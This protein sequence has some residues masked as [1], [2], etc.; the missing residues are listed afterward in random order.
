MYCRWIAGIGLPM[1]TD[2]LCGRRDPLSEL[3]AGDGVEAGQQGVHRA[4]RR[5]IADHLAAALPQRG[6]VGIAAQIGVDDL[7]QPQSRPMRGAGYL[8]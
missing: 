7:G 8:R 5:R 3:A 6:P 2:G 4:A 1:S